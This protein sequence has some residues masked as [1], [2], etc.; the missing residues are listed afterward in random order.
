MSAGQVTGLIAAQSIVDNAYLK[1][2]NIRKLSQLLTF[3]CNKAES[4]ISINNE[5]SNYAKCQVYFEEGCAAENDLDHT[6][7]KLIQMECRRLRDIV[8][9]VEIYFDPNPRETVI[10]EDQEFVED[11]W[12]FGLDEY[13]P[14]SGNSIPFTVRLTLDRGRKE[15][16]SIS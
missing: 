2:I 6:R 4:R 5:D 15:Y 9:K 8:L 16:F 10:S 11:W 1:W 12:A 13:S 14:V 7:E 3:N